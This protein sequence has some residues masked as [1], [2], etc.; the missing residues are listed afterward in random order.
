MDKSLRFWWVVILVLVI[1]FVIILTNWMSK[2]ETDN[3]SVSI[4]IPAK[5]EVLKPFAAKEND[6]K[7]AASGATQQENKQQVQAIQ[8]SSGSAVE[9]ENEDVVYE[10]PIRGPLTQ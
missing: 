10:A 4:K 5:V 2:D 6:V 8:S 7:G 9:E 3:V 1:M